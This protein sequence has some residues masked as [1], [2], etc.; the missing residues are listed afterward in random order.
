MGFNVKASKTSQKKGTKWLQEVGLLVQ[1]ELQTLSWM[2]TSLI[3][4]KYLQYLPEVTYVHIH[5][6]NKTVSV[7]ILKERL[8]PQY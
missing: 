3:N 6:Q 1:P 4:Q 5:I 7:Y 8:R 2:N